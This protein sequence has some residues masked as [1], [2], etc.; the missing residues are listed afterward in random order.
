MKT[1]HFWCL[2]SLIWGRGGCTQVDSSSQKSTFWVFSHS[3]K[4]LMKNKADQEPRE[5]LILQ[6]PIITSVNARSA[7]IYQLTFYSL[8]DCPWDKSSLNE[9]TL[10]SLLPSLSCIYLEYRLSYYNPIKQWW[11]S[12]CP[13]NCLAKMKHTTNTWGMSFNSNPVQFSHNVC[14]SRKR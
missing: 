10:E 1:L 3:L 8:C 14:C 7:L 9:L 4:H 2:L 5:G 11:S 13:D 12:K 6:T